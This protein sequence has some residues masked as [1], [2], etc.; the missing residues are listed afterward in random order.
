MDGFEESNFSRRVKRGRG[1]D[2]SQE[3]E[4]VSDR[5]HEGLGTG[6]LGESRWASAREPRGFLVQRSRE[7]SQMRLVKVWRPLNPKMHS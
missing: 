5:V 2:V 1:E 6:G 3:A 4:V 7:V